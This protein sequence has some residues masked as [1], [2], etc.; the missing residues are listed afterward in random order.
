MEHTLVFGWISS[1]DAVE[2]VCILLRMEW[3]EDQ[4]VVCGLG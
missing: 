2:G 3:D 4:G 1:H